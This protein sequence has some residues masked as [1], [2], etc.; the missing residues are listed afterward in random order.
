MSK[1]LQFLKMSAVFL[2]VLLLG[3]TA[4]Y[5]TPVTVENASFEF[6]SGTTFRSKYSLGT[7][8]LR[9]MDGWTHSG[10]NDS[11]GIWDPNPSVFSSVPDGNYIGYL[12]GGSLFQ[13]LDRSVVA[14]NTLT[15]QID[16]GNYLNVDQPAYSVELW[17][18]NDLL[19]SD[20]SVVPID[21]EF[22]TLTLL[23]NVLDG[24]PHIGKS[25]GIKIVSGGENLTFDNVR[26][27]ND[28]NNS[29]VPEPATMLLLGSGL[30]CLAGFGRKKFLKK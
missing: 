5:A 2:C 24:D 18:D 4:A 27:S 16:I 14:N 7:W 6:S 13:E 17:A 10:G 12:D 19:V 1:T 9:D 8:S 20:G 3:F 29:P 11:W 23:Y 21:G 28:A 22:S 25:L 15:M 26:F 30:A